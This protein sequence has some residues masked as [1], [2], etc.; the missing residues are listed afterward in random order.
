[1]KHSRN[2]ED[3][4]FYHLVWDVAWF[5]VAWVTIN[6]FLSV[7][8]LRV[9]A[10]PTELSWITAG[11]VLGMALGS[12]LVIWWRDRFP[13]SVKA[14]GI[15]TFLFR[16]TFLLLAFTPLFP[17]RWQPLWIIAAVTIPSLPQGLSNIIFYGVLKEATPDSRMT[18]LLGQRTL[19]VNV[20]LGASALMFG[21]WLERAPYPYNYALMF[22]FA[23]VAALVSQWHLS[24]V[25]PLDPEAVKPEPAT[26]KRDVKPLQDWRFRQVLWVSA[27]SYIAFFSV[28]PV[29]AIRLVDELNAGEGFMAVFSVVELA[30][31][32]FMA[33]FITRIVKSVGNRFMIGAAMIVTAVAALVM[34]LVPSLPL[35]LIGAILTGA[36]WSTAEIGI[37]GY[38][39]QNSPTRDSARYTRIY[40]QAVW[41]AIFVAPFMGTFLVEAE[42]PLATVILLG[43]GLRFLAGFLAMQGARQTLIPTGNA[44]ST[45]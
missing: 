43:A 40:S 34:A 45:L 42:I 14:I 17:E 8:A 4:N 21:I 5:G 27:L 39:T 41:A 2:L 26:I 35:T 11:P 24:R 6:R 20:A 1:M 10:T 3:H 38:F 31:G 37:V 32:A 25:R 18:P 22:S 28:F 7:Y 9:G 36:G 44:P 13:D 23:F 16:F 29:I 30:G 15:P 12:L 33:L 19:V